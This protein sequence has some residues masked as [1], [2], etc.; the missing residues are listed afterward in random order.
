MTLKAETGTRTL[1]AGI[2][3]SGRNAAYEYAFSTLNAEVTL[4]GPI[5]DLDRLDP[6]T[7]TVPI[8]VA[9]LAPGV[10]EVAPSLNLQA[11]LRLLS[12]GPATVTVTITLRASPAPSA[13]G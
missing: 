13:G 7:F 6:A 12:V 3:V 5:A 9:G 11:G 2:V 4:A 10:H 1:A 8:D